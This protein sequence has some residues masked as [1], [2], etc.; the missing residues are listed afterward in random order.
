MTMRAVRRFVRDLLRQR[1]TRALRVDPARDAEL[2]TAIT[3]RA[4]RPGAGAPSEEFVATLRQRL[5]A[6][7]DDAPA[8][9]P[10]TRR[11]RIVQ[12]ASL[13]AASAA[14][15]A[16]LDDLLTPRPGTPRPGTEPTARAGAQAGPTLSPDSGEWSTVAVTAD[17][18][19][20]G[21]RPFDLGTVVGFVRRSGGRVHAVSGVCTHLGCRLA[22]NAPAGQLDC[23]CHN[24]SFGVDGRVL[25]HRLPI[26]LAALPVITTRELGGEVQVFVPRAG[27]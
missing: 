1:R 14:V 2:R 10:V 26:T 19:E 24:A 4:A 25:H 23:P 6:E 16:G 21:V 11:R 27:A 20:G 5:A 17:L 9:R 22:L 12:V 8:A 18:P 3:L 13:A 7:L 15:G